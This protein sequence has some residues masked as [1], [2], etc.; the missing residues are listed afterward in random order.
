MPFM[1]G[2]EVEAVIKQGDRVFGYM[3]ASCPNCERTRAYV[4]YAKQNDGGWFAE[5]PNGKYPALN[6]TGQQIDQIKRDPDAFLSMF[7][8]S[9]RIQIGD[10]P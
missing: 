4:I 3:W 6:H 8:E 9:S 10:I 5:F 2:P 1:T 7:P